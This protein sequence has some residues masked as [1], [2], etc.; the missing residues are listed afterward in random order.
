MPELTSLEF[1][2]PEYCYPHYNSTARFK[3]NKGQE[4]IIRVSGL[5]Q[6]IVEQY[7]RS[8]HAYFE[9]STH[10]SSQLKSADAIPVPQGKTEQVLVAGKTIHLEGNVEPLLT[11]SIAVVLEV[12]KDQDIEFPKLW[13][14]QLN[15]TIESIPIDG[16]NFQEIDVRYE[17]PPGRPQVDITVSEGSVD[18]KL[19]QVKGSSLELVD[20]QIVRAEN[21]DKQPIRLT[22]RDNVSKGTSFLIQVKGLGDSRSQYKIN[23]TWTLEKDSD[24]IPV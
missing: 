11:N 19:F 24:F 13:N 21:D 3:N 18:V 4:F 23:G 5:N 8:L 6:A 12:D 10:E 2:Q 17:F 1:S 9:V 20:A 7:T 14:F 16:G 22:T 15:H